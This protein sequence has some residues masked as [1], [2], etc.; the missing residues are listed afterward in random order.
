MDVGIADG[1][2][3]NSLTFERH[4]KQNHFSQSQSGGRDGSWEGVVRTTD[5][6]GGSIP[7]AFSYSHRDDYETRLVYERTDGTIVPLKGSGTDGGHGL[8]NSLTSLPVEE[9]ETIKRFH[10]QSRRYEWIEFQHVS[11]QLG[12]RTNVEVHSAY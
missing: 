11:L 1:D 2:W 8:T 3:K 7:L 9:F 4:P 12:H 6:S 10:V 5:P